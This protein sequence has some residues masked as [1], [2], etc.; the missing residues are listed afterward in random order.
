MSPDD[1]CFWLASL[2][3]E[4]TAEAFTEEDVILARSILSDVFQ[5]A[6]DPTMGDA[7]HLAILRR[8]HGM[9]PDKDNQQ[10]MLKR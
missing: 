1:F 10:V 6:I 8:I 9:T 4:R 3:A 7:E 2:L 5:H